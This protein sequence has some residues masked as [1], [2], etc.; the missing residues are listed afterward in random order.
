LRTHPS[1]G[2]RGVAAPAVN[3]DLRYDFT[4]DNGPIVRTYHVETKPRFDLLEQVLA[5]LRSMEQPR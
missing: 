5:K 4:K 1:R 3:H 2:L